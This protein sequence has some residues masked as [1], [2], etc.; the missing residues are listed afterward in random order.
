MNLGIVSNYI[1]ILPFGFMV[2]AQIV[3]SFSVFFFM[4]SGIIMNVGVGNLQYNKTLMFSEI[5]AM[6]GVFKRSV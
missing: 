3:I 4:H 2:I 5:G 1:C 6:H